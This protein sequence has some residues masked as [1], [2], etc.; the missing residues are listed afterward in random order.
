MTAKQMV[1]EFCDL[2]VKRDAELLRPYLGDSVVYQNVGMAATTG[3]EDVIANLAG[4]FAMF[5]NSYEY[6]TINI[7]ADGDVVMNE[8]L[9]MV[10]G[11]DGSGHALPVMG[12]FVVTDGKIVRWTDYWDSGLIGKMMTGDDYG[13]LVPRY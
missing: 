9:D 5:P 10:T 7:A 2:M 12:T 8:R 13:E 3:I 4:Q 6:K 1:Q 11:P